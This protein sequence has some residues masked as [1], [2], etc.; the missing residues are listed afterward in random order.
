MSRT[1]ARIAGPDR[2]RLDPGAGRAGEPDAGRPGRPAGRRPGRAGQPQ[3]QHPVRGH[4]PAGPHRRDLPARRADGARRKGRQMKR[5]AHSRAGGRAD[6]PRRG[7]RRGRGDVRRG[8]LHHRDDRL[9]G[10]ADRP[11]VPP[12]GRGADR[13]AHRQHRRQR[14]GRRVRPD[15]GRRLR[16]ARPGPAAVELALHRRPGGPAGRR[17]RR[18]HLRHRH[19]GADPAPAR[20]RRDAGRRLQRR[21]RSGGA[22]GAGARRARRWSAPT[23]R[24]R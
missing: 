5:S 15:L 3:P 6:V 21:R 14:R 10:D 8:G 22:A 1:P 17:G 18:R 12:A 23:C 24:P 2:P 13:A 7:V 4:D 9:P 11:V 20:A 16:G 19:P